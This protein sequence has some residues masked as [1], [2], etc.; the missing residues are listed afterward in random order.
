MGKGDGSVEDTAIIS[1]LT[2]QHGIPEAHP[3][4][5]AM[6]EAY[7]K[8]GAP[9]VE[10]LKDY[11]SRGGMKEREKRA[12]E[13]ASLAKQGEML[14]SREKI[15]RDQ[16]DSRERIEKAR[17]AERAAKRADDATKNIKITGWETGIISYRQAY[18]EALSSGNMELA[19][20]I[21][22]LLNEA[23]NGWN[24]KQQAEQAKKLPIAPPGLP[25]TSAPQ[26]PQAGQSAAPAAAVQKWGRDK[27]GNPVPLP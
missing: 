14:E 26:M 6:R 4:V 21:Q 11:I 7:M 5:Q 15:A 12:Q 8:G 3:I 25:V 23:I 1:S 22:K 19:S 18:E 24:L 2:K 9:A 13:E 17:L 27:N 16:I 20:R 10:K